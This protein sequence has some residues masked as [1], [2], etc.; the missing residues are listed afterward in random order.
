[1]SKSKTTQ[2]RLNILI[3]IDE[4]DDD[5]R[6]MAAPFRRDI[7]EL[8]AEVPKLLAGILMIDPKYVRL[9]EI[10]EG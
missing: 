6:T 9:D 8:G 2:Y 7:K 10:W 1:M 4:E 5:G 3:S